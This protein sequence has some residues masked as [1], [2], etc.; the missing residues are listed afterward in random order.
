[1]QESKSKTTI[2][3]LISAAG[4]GFTRYVVRPRG[5]P[6]FHQIR[7][8]PFVRRH[9]LFTEAKRRKG[10]ETVTLDFKRRPTIFN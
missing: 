7:Y 9:V 1:L 8:D 3:K 2:I 4:T 6:V 5:S 10:V